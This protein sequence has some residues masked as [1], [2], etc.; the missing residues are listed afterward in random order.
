M[1]DEPDLTDDQGYL[2]RMMEDA[3]SKVTVLTTLHNDLEVM[4][5]QQIRFAR[6]MLTVCSALA[7][8][9]IT[10][11]A[12]GILL[13]G[14][15]RGA[16][17]DAASATAGLTLVTGQNRGFIES[18]DNV[19]RKAQENGAATSKQQCRELEKLKAAIRGVIRSSPQGQS[20]AADVA[21]DRFRRRNCNKLP[22]AKPVQP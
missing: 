4:R 8:I 16:Q 21:V 1:T 18:L 3:G 7:L 15:V 17:R 20:A 2:H 13:I 11:L 10:A 12:I 22:N 5:E 19:A 9:A 6:R 14:D